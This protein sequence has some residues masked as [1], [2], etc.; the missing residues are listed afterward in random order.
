M[1]GGGGGCKVS[2]QSIIAYN[3]KGAVNASFYLS[4][5]PELASLRALIRFLS[6]STLTPVQGENENYLLKAK[7]FT[8]HLYSGQNVLQKIMKL[9]LAPQLLV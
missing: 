6:L 8:F 5:F 4:F 3:M 2:G 9:V 7:S 1:G